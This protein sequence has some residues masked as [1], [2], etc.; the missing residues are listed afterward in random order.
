MKIFLFIIYILLM[1]IAVDLISAF[2]VFKRP[3]WSKRE[4]FMFNKK[5]KYREHILSAENFDG[6]LSKITFILPVYYFN[7]C[8]EDKTWWVIPFSPLYWRIR[9]HYK[10]MGL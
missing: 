8:K 3:L 9:R 4:V 5:N 10:N 7:S 1:A 6:F 2:I